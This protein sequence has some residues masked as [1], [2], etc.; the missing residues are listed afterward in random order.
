MRQRAYIDVNA[1]LGRTSF[2]EERIPYTTEALLEEM[3]YYR[4]HASLAYSNVAREYAFT[5]GNDELIEE[6]KKSKRLFGVGTI[7]PGIQFELEQGMGYCDELL[8]KGIRAF[9]VFPNSLHH[10][11]DRFSMQNIAEYLMK[12]NVPLLVD[13][14]EI[15]WRNLAEIMETYVELKIVLCNTSW[16]HNRYLLPLMEKYQNLY[17]EISSNQANDILTTCKKHFGVERVLFGTNYPNKVMGGLKALV[18]YSELSEEDKDKIACKNAM[19]LFNITDIELYK[20]EEC[21]LDEYALTMENGKPFDNIPIIDAH[22]HIVDGSHYTVSHCPIINSDEHNLIRKMDLLGIDKI[23]ISS[24]EGLATSGISANETDLHAKEKYE[25]RIEVYAMCNPHYQKDLDAVVDIY[26]EKFR[27][28][29]LKPYYSFNQY[30]LLGDK[31]DKWFEYGNKNKL[32]MLV[33]SGLQGIA[34][35]V[36]VLSQKYPDMAFLLAHSGSSYW[37]ARENIAVAKKRDNVFLEITYT[38]LTNGIIEYM[39][40]EVGADKVIFGT[41]MPM[42]DP[43][44]QLA[45]VCYARISMEDKKKIL[46]GNISKLIDR[47]YKK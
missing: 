23:M 40:E 6:I 35:K 19:K 43:A 14:H 38:S 39:V 31:Y 44:P 27:F 42:R 45:W 30:D 26:H 28:I 5:K 7:I 17:F 32:I 46:A 9:K 8:E 22:T 13:A 11:F 36:D 47:C 34:E 41:D 4:V 25:D 3:K 21:M 29:G 37:A 12:K 33:H 24:W 20:E 15:D 16:G 1:G 10:G 2:R 18:E